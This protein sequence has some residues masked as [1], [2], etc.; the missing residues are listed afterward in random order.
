MNSQSW[1]EINLIGYQLCIEKN[2]HYSY[3][4]SQHSFWS[5][6][7]VHD[8]MFVWRVKSCKSNNEDTEATVY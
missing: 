8:C 2:E 1:L 7:P 6:G 4:I 3:L 5:V